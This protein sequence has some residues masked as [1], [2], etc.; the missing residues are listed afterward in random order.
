ML[1]IYTLSR[2]FII[3]DKLKLLTCATRY[4]TKSSSTEEQNIETIANYAESEQYW[5]KISKEFIHNDK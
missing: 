5:I 4:R 2:F 1:L 3:Y